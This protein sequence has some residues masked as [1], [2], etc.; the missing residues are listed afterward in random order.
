MSLMIAAV[1]QVVAGFRCGG[2]GYFADGPSRRVY[3]VGW[4]R[5]GRAA[6]GMDIRSV[7]AGRRHPEKNQALNMH[8]VLQGGWRELRCAGEQV[9]YGHNRS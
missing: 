5:N 2:S 6:V 9:K 8:A 3:A 1:E 4:P 7:I